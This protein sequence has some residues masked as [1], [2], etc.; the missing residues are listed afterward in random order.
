MPRGVPLSRSMVRLRQLVVRDEGRFRVNLSGSVAVPR[1]PGVGATFLF[2]MASAN[3]GFHSLRKF[4]LMAL[5]G[6]HA[7]AIIASYINHPVAAGEDCCRRILGAPDLDLIKHVKQECILLLMNSRSICLSVRPE[8]MQWILLS[9]S[10]FPRKRESR[11]P[12]LRRLP[13]LPAFAG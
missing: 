13:W 2:T 10:S 5:C 9:C 3:F 6:T 1:T 11:I 4:K 7:I 12:A 8:T